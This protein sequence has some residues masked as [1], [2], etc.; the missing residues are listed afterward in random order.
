MITLVCRDW[1]CDDAIHQHR[2]RFSLCQ[3]RLL[4]NSPVK[5]HEIILTTIM[6]NQ[7]NT[8]MYK[9]TSAV[10][11]NDANKTLSGF[12]SIIYLFILNHGKSL[13]KKAFFYYK[14]RYKQ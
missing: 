9:Y 1:Q 7:F 13:T 8:L 3:S 11:N 4:Y 14:P 6:L 12:K 10:N 2:E 5:Q